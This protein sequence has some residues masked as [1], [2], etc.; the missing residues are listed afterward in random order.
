MVV[1][2]GVGRCGV[3]HGCVFGGCGRDGGEKVTAVFG[4]VCC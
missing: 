3:R 1:K 4:C 2:G